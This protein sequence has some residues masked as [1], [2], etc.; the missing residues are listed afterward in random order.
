M[1]DGQSTVGQRTFQDKLNLLKIS[2]NE[3]GFTVVY[4]STV[5]I[6]HL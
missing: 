2:Y 5:Q 6:Q 1:Q 4:F 3:I